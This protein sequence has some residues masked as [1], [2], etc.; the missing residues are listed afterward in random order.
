MNASRSA[1]RPSASP[2]CTEAK[3]PLARSSAAIAW[4]ALA[5][6]SSPAPPSAMSTMREA[7]PLLICSS[8]SS[9]IGVA[10]GGRKAPR[11]ATT[12]VRASCAALSA[13]SSSHRA[14]ASRGR[15]LPIVQDPHHRAVAA[16]LDDLDA[17][18][19]GLGAREGDGLDVALDLGVARRKAQRPAAARAGEME[20]VVALELRKIAG[21]RRAHALD[22][23]A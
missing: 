2:F 12:R 8:R 15:S 18:Q 9:C 14:T 21:E 3:R 1:R 20:L 10:D 5:K 13:R 23:R 7:T 16:C 19:A 11:S 4:L 22:Q 17:P 6:R